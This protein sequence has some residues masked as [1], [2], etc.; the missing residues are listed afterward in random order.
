MIH[1]DSVDFAR[2]LSEHLGASCSRRPS[3]RRPPAQRRLRGRLRHPG[4]SRGEAE[5]SPPTADLGIK[6]TTRDGIL[7]AARGRGLRHPRQ[8]QRARGRHRRSQT[9]LNILACQERSI[10]PVKQISGRGDAPTAASGKTHQVFVDI[11]NSILRIFNDIDAMRR[12]DPERSRRQVRGLAAP[13]RQQFEMWFDTDPSLPDQITQRLREIRKRDAAGDT[14]ATTPTSSIRRCPGTRPTRCR[15]RTRSPTAARRRLAALRFRGQGLTPAAWRCSA[16]CGSSGSTGPTSR[17]TCPAGRRYPR[18]EA[19]REPGLP[20]QRPRHRPALRRLHRRAPRPEVRGRGATEKQVEYHTGCSARRSTYYQKWLLPFASPT[21]KAHATACIDLLKGTLFARLSPRAPDI[22]ERATGRKDIV[23]PLKA[24]ILERPN[25]LS[26]Q[27]QEL[28]GA[29]CRLHDR[30]KTLLPKEP[31][32][33]K[34]V[35]IVTYDLR[36]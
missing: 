16:T 19:R 7:D 8:R 10:G 18:R 2:A 30:L 14:G 3:A 35:S 25:Q 34:P 4:L 28:L 23:H 13:I 17:A 22:V 24:V 36:A 9:D 6:K 31:N 5:T 20:V 1:C 33:Q 32:Y 26:P 12:N 29:Y 27:R 21:G 15:S 11:G